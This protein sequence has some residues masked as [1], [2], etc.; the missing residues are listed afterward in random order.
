M[1]PSRISTTSLNE[2]SDQDRP[3]TIL[4]V[5]GGHSVFWSTALSNKIYRDSLQNPCFKVGTGHSLGN[6]NPANDSLIE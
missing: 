5:T 2:K 4:I 6:R 1:S 3:R